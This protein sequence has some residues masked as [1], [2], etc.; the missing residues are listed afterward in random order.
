M[1]LALFIQN[2][3]RMRRIVLSS[4]TFVALSYFST[5]S[6]KRYDLQEKRL[7]NI[8]CVLIFFTTLNYFH[9]KKNSAR[10]VKKIYIV[11]R[12]K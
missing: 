3:K 10:Y 9:S 11:F 6:H 7:L 1:S 2:A 4:V 12:V 8:K 5:L